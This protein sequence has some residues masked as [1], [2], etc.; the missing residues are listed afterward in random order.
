MSRVPHTQPRPVPVK[1]PAPQA[2]APTAS[3]LNQY[4]SGGENL[5]PGPDPRRA[6]LDAA[7]PPSP[8]T[9][10]QRAAR[11][12]EIA[13]GGAHDNVKTICIKEMKKIA[14][15]IQL[16]WA[17]YALERG[18]GEPVGQPTLASVYAR[19]EERLGGL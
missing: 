7:M 4:T 10:L 13:A 8:A 12:S 6:G 18:A 15:E 2:L 14:K 16:E 19:I 1:P 5:P 17:R 9:P 3:P 11:S